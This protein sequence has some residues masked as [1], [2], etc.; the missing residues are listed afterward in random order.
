MSQWSLSSYEL[1]EDSVNLIGSTVISA[2]AYGIMFTLYT[3]ASH[4]LVQNIRMSKDDVPL[5]RRSWCFLAYISAMF[6]LGTICMA[7]NAR[8]AQIAYVYRP[9]YNGPNSAT[10]ANSI[11]HQS[12]ILMGSVSYILVCMMADCLVFWRVTVVYHNSR[13]WLWASLLPAFFLCGVIAMGICV[14]VKAYNLDLTFYSQSSTQFAVPYYACSLALSLTSTILI[15]ARLCLYKRRLDRSPIGGSVASPYLGIIV[16]IIE[17]SGL[18]ALWSLLFLITYITNNPFQYMFLPSLA[19]VQIIAPLL[20]ILFVVQGR[21]WYQQSILASVGHIRFAPRPL[22]R[23]ED[24]Q[25][26]SHVTIP[27]PV[28]YPMSKGGSTYRPRST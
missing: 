3:I 14:I 25:I 19:Q 27:H 12:V 18:Y 13:Y 9:N 6:I 15:V 11:R 7:S 2:V 5:R 23:I 10:Y 24:G 1:F 4:A 8:G 28:T 21:G 22:S 26:D 16:I 17:S 20:I